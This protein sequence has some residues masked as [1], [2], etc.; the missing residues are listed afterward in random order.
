MSEQS[1]ESAD[2]AAW[3]LSWYHH[4]EDGPFEYHGPWWVSGY[5]FEPD[6]TIVVAAVPAPTEDAAWDVIQTAYDSV[7]E[8][9]DRRFIEPLTGEPWTGPEGRF[10]RADWMR[11]PVSTPPGERA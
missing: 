8:D 2:T 4:P 11:W 9:I 3:W 5:A 10:P 6:R 7:P 1:A